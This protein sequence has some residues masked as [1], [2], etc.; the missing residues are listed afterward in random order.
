M[1]QKLVGE[2][3]AEISDSGAPLPERDIQI[4][5]GLKSSEIGELIAN[6]V[7]NDISTIV[8]V[9]S[10]K[11]AE[12]LSLRVKDIL[13]KKGRED[14]VEKVSP[15]RS[16]YTPE[17]RREIEFKIMTKNV[18]AV[19]STSALEMGIDIGEIESCILVGY[20][21]TLAQLWQ[22]FGRAG[23]RNKKAYN[24]LIPK[25][26]ALDQYFVKNPEEIFCRQMEEPVINPLN[27]YILKKHIPV[28]AFE[29][30]I[31]IS[32]MSETEKEVARELYREKKLKFANN[33]LYASKQEPFSIR[34]AG[35][36]Y[37]IVESI[38]GK[39]VGDIS[40]DIMIYETYPGAVYL[41]NGEKYVV[42][43]ISQEDK[44]VY[45]V[46]SDVSYITEPLKESFIE[47]V[48][49][50]DSKTVGKIQIFKGKVNV[51]TTVVGYSM[52]DIEKEEKLKDEVFSE[53]RYLTREFETVAFWWTV[54]AE[55]EEEI[56]QRNMRHNA[57]LLS[58]FIKEKGRLYTGDFV[59]G[60][61]V[62]EKLLNLRI[63]G[64]IDHLLYVI[65]ATQ[66]LSTK[67]NDKEKE[68]FKEY[69]RRIKEKENSF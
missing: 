35:D 48:N 17:E 33:K 1:P 55:W 49:I 40:E 65:K 53:D 28:M 44:A 52:R 56:I 6:T 41:H 68:F 51:R 11:E 23:R 4:L 61:V 26:N 32:E 8:F 14:L 47:I 30:P 64:D 57:R 62:S 59:Y 24:I 43:N 25:R 21:G 18:L 34:S 69:I 58:H 10:R 63:D 5:K 27:R 16:G 29:L 38:T 9:D 3:V 60:D 22:R 50:E 7:I 46:K 13:I 37:S 2:D 12:L 19:I 31:K 20:P 66:S 67:L 45:V 42:E 15:Y 36:S 39:I 54:P